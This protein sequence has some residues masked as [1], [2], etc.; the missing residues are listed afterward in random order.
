MDVLSNSII[1]M[2]YVRMNFAIKCEPIKNPWEKISQY[3]NQGNLKSIGKIFEKQNG[4]LCWM[5]CLKIPVQF[6]L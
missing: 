3:T 2:F 4:L 1:E 6:I 5:I